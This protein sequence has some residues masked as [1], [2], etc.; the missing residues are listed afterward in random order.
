[1]RF[2]IPAI[3]ILL[4]CG[5]G[6]T[7]NSDSAEETAETDAP[8]QQANDALERTELEQKQQNLDALGIGGATRR[9]QEIQ[10]KRNQDLEEALD[11]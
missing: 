9:V 7:P 3:A 2:L 6:E 4:C 5:C 10:D 1:M 11:K 8:S